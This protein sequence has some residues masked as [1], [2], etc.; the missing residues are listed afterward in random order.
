MFWGYGQP[1]GQW[2]IWVSGDTISCYL[3]KPYFSTL[4]RAGYGASLDGM[5]SVNYT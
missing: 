1:S 5:V 4:G 2:E 3:L